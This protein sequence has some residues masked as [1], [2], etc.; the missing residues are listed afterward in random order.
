MKFRLTMTYEYTPDPAN[1]QDSHPEA[2]AA[3]DLKNFR[4]WPDD[5]LYAVFEMDGKG[6]EAIQIEIIEE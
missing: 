3:V 4:D 5:L 1:Y 6:P 2:M